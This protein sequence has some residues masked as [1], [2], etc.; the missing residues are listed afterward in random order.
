MEQY[1]R[2]GQVSWDKNTEAPITLSQGSIIYYHWEILLYNI[3]CT[4]LHTES[5]LRGD[6]R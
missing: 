5:T 2:I 3:P 4:P 1:S 6:L